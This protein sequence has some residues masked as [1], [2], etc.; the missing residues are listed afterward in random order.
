L[1][2][3]SE[4]EYLIPGLEQPSTVFF[5][6]SS[7]NFLEHWHVWLMPALLHRGNPVTNIQ[8]II[9]ARILTSLQQ[10]DK[11]NPERLYRE[12][13]AIDFQ[14]SQRLTLVQPAEDSLPQKREMG[15]RHSLHPHLA[16]IIEETLNV[17]KKN[18][19][20]RRQATGDQHKVLCLT[21]IIL[22]I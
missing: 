20:M 21:I 6:L 15:H 22:I 2:Y 7:A 1:Q 9:L 8:F 16:C 5:L 11:W 13:M 10:A 4:D 3:L 12:I 14:H 17:R 19:Y 18:E